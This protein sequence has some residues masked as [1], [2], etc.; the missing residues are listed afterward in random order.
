MSHTHLLELYAYIGA[1]KRETM[2]RR[3][4]E[5]LPAST[6]KAAEGADTFLDEAMAFFSSSYHEKLPKRLR[7][8]HPAQGYLP[9]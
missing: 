9:V 5:I 4:D 2:D 1:R 6:R 3:L 8:K 7:I